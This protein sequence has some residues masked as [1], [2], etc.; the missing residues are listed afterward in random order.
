MVTR[1]RYNGG[2]VSS[3]YAFKTPYF[4]T[5]V[6]NP[7][8]IASVSSCQTADRHMAVPSKGALP[9]MGGG[10]RKSGGARKKSRK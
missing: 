7:Y 10:A 5:L 3:D 1:K 6:Q 9:G 8:A 2:G 4:G